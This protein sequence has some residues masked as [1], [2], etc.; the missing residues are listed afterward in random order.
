ME[1]SNIADFNFSDTFQTDDRRFNSIPETDWCKLKNLSSRKDNNKKVFDETMPGYSE[2]IQKNDLLFRLS[3]GSDS[4]FNSFRNES[5]QS[6][7]ISLSSLANNLDNLSTDGLLQDYNKDYS[8]ETSNN[9]HHFSGILV[10]KKNIIKQQPI[11]FG[12]LNQE[13]E[14]VSE[15]LKD[16]SLSELAAAHKLECMKQNA[17]L[18]RSN[19]DKLGQSS[20]KSSAGKGCEKVLMSKKK[21]V[22]VEGKTNRKDSLRKSPSQFGRVLCRKFIAS[23]RLQS[24]CMLKDLQNDSETVS[25]S[26]DFHYKKMMVAFDF[27]TPSPDDIVKKN[28]KFAF[29]PKKI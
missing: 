3:R 11:L 21:D 24:F 7:P 27:S 14:N 19:M 1:E 5:I 16:L 15:S 22:S 25:K 26:V 20:M 10:E 2:N 17:K 28:Q 18:N 4:C 23:D 9:S 29:V 6:K 8:S 13:S 12:C